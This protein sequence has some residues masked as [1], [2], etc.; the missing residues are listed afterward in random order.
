MPE[1]SGTTIT[2]ADGVQ[3]PSMNGSTSGNFL[4]SALKSYMLSGAG[5]ANGLA[6]LGSDGKLPAAQLPDL[7]DDVIV[8]TTYSNLPSPGTAS[9]IYI[10]ADTNKGYR[11][12]PDLTTPAYV[13]LFEMDKCVVFGYY[14]SGSFYEDSAHTVEITT[15]EKVLYVDVSISDIYVLEDGVLI[16]LLASKYAK[17]ADIQDGTI[18]AGVATKAWQDILGNAI[19]TTYATKSETSD[20]K[21]AIDGMNARVENLEQEHGGYYETVPP[22][23]PNYAKS[24]F[25]IPSGKAKNWIVDRLRGVGRVEN[26][27]FKASAITGFCTRVSDTQISVSFGTD[28]SSYPIPMD[29]VQTVNGHLYLFYLKADS[30]TNIRTAVNGII[31]Y[32]SDTQI[33]SGVVRIL[34]GDG[35][36]TAVQFT[37][38]TAGV[39]GSGNV[40]FLFRDLNIYFNTTDLSFLGATDSA[41]LATIQ[42]SYPWLLLPSDY[43]TEVRWTRYEGIKSKHR[44]IYD[45]TSTDVTALTASGTTEVNSARFTT[46]Y[47]PIKDSTISCNLGGSY[48][49]YDFNKNFISGEVKSLSVFRNITVP[50]GAFYVRFDC[51]KATVT[52]SAF[53]V[54]NGTWASEDMADYIPYGTIATLTLSSPLELKGVGTVAEEAYLNEDGEAWKTNLIE[55]ITFDGSE[56]WSKAGN[57]GFYVQVDD[58]VKKTNY[59]GFLL[60]DSGF[61]VVNNDS[62]VLNTDMSIS[63]YSDA[64]SSYPNQNWIYIRINTSITT[65]SGV[66]EWLEEHPL[67]VSFVLATPSADTPI[68]PV[69]NNLLPTEAGGTIES[70]LTNPV[71]DSMTLG[72]L[73]L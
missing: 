35:N 22:T 14:S 61:S 8:V 24:P 65:S 33:E 50:S 55:T 27:L 68:T 29:T 37:P 59:I 45:G 69:L 1:Y 25:V 42:S 63:G 43:G 5:Q 67:T 72:Y 48:A 10:T 12:D 49:F 6:T 20:L 52:P 57:Y 53:M 2:P 13:Q 41:K 34:T 58:L 39:G 26:Q 47:I 18:T 70:V 21:D 51:I 71:D 38:A 46:G 3:V 54:F 73:N 64:G 19:I 23:Y 32:Y 66:K 16:E 28:Y 36:T 9:K 30:G 44:N 62:T 11:W 60:A 7:A 31:P 4:L 17:V 56:Q 40:F 15:V